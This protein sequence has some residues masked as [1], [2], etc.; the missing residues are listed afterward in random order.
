MVIME[1]TIFGPFKEIQFSDIV[2]GNV[3]GK[4]S[5]HNE[6]SSEISSEIIQHISSFDTIESHYYRKK[7]IKQRFS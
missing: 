5:S 4:C 7:Y 2:V 3:R 6:I 1:C